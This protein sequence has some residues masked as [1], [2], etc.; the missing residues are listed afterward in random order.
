MFR[1]IKIPFDK[2]VV[3]KERRGASF[4]P[5]QIEKELKN[6]FEFDSLSKNIQFETIK[7]LDDFELMQKEIE[8]CASD[9]YEKKEFVLGLGGDHSVSYGLVNAFA[10]KF[11]KKSGLIWFDAHFD[12]QD[13]FFPPTH[14]DVLRAI[15]KANF[16]RKNKS[17][18]SILHIGARNYTD[19]E[20]RFVFNKIAFDLAENFYTSAFNN[21][22]K[23]IKEF[24]KPLNAIY[25]S[26]D[27]DVLDPAFALGTGWP[28]PAG[29]LPQ[30]LLLILEH[31]KAT[32]KVKGL[33]IVEVCPPK[34]FQNQTSRLA[35]KI[36]LNFLKS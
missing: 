10:K 3:E 11:S 18:H 8:K 20:K 31:L 29:L 25:L 21:V 30:Q 17:I 4:A 35:A 34:D 28:E 33:D 1:V 9:A 19:A 36:A 15:I 22:I 6:F 14:E 13:D 12:C 7:E 32:K 23:H 26:I 24:A 16:F 27:I 2:C 5:D